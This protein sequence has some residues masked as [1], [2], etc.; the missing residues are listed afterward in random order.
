MCLGIAHFEVRNGT[1][2]NRILRKMRFDGTA[3]KGYDVAQIGCDVAQLGCDVA[4]MVVHQLAVRQA[5]V[6]SIPDSAPQE[7]FFLTELT[8]DEEMERNLAASGDG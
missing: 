7:G 2:R 6:S 5:R 4:Q 1:K 8:S 3:R